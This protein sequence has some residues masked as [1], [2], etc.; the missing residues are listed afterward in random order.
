MFSEHSLTVTGIQILSAGSHGKYV[1]LRQ[2]C[3][4]LHTIQIQQI[5]EVL[6]FKQGE[7]KKFPSKA[8]H[9]TEFN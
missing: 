8:V 9:S 1:V 4:P 2:K 3:R 5:R 6:L 7:G